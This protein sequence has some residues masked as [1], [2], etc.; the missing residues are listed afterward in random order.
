MEMLLAGCSNDEHL[1]AWYQYIS[2]MLPKI[3]FKC[4]RCT[5]PQLHTFL[6]LLYTSR[7]MLIHPQLFEYQR[8][9]DSFAAWHRY[10]NSLV[11]HLAL[12]LMYH[13][14][15]HQT[16]FQRRVRSTSA[17]VVGSQID[18]WDWFVL[19]SSWDSRLNCSVCAFELYWADFGNLDPCCWS[20]Q[21][22]VNRGED[23]EISN[24]CLA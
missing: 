12:L 17:M 7:H 19:P 6:L 11:G 5:H 9:N 16:A 1:Q 24:Y 22:L 2:S 15:N 3:C 13:G 4:V 23:R 14:L 21:N 8:L 10:V 18:I 20:H